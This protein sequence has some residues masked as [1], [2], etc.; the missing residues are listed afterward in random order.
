MAFTDLRLN[1]AFFVMPDG[2][3]LRP[4]MVKTG[5]MTAKFRGVPSR[6]FLFQPTARVIL[7]LSVRNV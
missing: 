4:R 5:G 7:D 3:G 1:D 6:E 2:D